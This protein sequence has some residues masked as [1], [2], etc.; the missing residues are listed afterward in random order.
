MI[1]DVTGIILKPSNNGEDCDGNGE[2]TDA[3]GNRL[4]CCCEECDCYLECF[5]DCTK[6]DINVTFL[7]F[8]R[9]NK[10]H[11]FCLY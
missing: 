11:V 10:H 2:H 3:F 5:T 6:Q 4:E 7:S 8:D 1:I 9:Q